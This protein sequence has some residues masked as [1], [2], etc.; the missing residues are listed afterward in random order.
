MR[1]MLTTLGCPKNVVDSE[2]MAELLRE[3]G[4]QPVA[5][6]PEADVL[7]VNTCA[8]IAP[9]RDESYAV[10]R[11]LADGKRRGQFLVV[12]GCMAQRYGL[13]L[14]RRVPE[15][16]AVIGTRSWPQIAVL[17]AQLESGGRKALPQALVREEAELV[18]SVRRRAELGASAYLKIADGCNAS[19]AFCAI[20]GIKGP[21]QSKPRE[22]ILR[23][24]RELADLGVRELLLI[25]QDTT[26]YG[27]DLGQ[28]DALP[29]LLRD[30]VQAAPAL[31]WVRVLY[32]YPQHVSQR[33]IDTMAELPQVCHYFDL[34]LQHGHPDVLRRMRRPHDASTV[35][36]LLRRVRAAMPDVSL[37]TAF[38]VGYPGETEVE[39][40][41][42][43]DLMRDEAFDKVGVFAYSREEGTA[44]ARLPGRVPARV[45]E[46]RR[47]R[48]MLLQ[49]EIS[50]A[51]NREQVGRELPVLIEGVGEGVSVG[52]SY[53]D[54]P[55]IDGVVL[56]AGEAPV[57]Q[58]V[59]TR[60]VA[61]QEYDLIGEWLDAPA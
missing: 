18:A 24:A 14:R 47:E 28:A 34:P 15:I 21:Q 4:H 46:E 8:F 49:Q 40:E 7:I 37:R 3:A 43:L 31:E 51:R 32:A 29:G 50:L 41:A 9:A 25:A 42:L 5:E 54:A 33:L 53:R 10:L 55:E 2:M 13:A 6:A 39:F 16:D 17:L 30:I 57:G 22:A 52:R 12:A 45:V 11:E 36:D 20:P 35:D 44:A 56:L 61:A 1:F 23:E 27:H 48:A 19:C 60:I 58:F 26:A 38:I 59:R